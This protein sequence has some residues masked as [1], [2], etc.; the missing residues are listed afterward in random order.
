MIHSA[1]VELTLEKGLEHATIEAIADEANVSPRT[2]FNY[3]N[4]KEDAILGM[5]EPSIAEHGWNEFEP[6]GDLLVKASRLLLTVAQST[7]GGDRATSRRYEV[8]ARYP[9]LTQR[10]LSYIGK[11]EKLVLELVHQRLT[12]SEHWRAAAPD[13]PPRE[14]AQVI[15]SVSSATVRFVMQQGSPVR[16]VTAQFEALDAASSFFQRVLRKAI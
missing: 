2:F 7:F 15:V 10:R 9:E 8:Q 5:Q 4:S 11:A 6:T 12:E 14:A 1:A 13:L 3:F 16:D